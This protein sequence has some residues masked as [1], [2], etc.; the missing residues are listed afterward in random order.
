VEKNEVLP[1]NLEADVR[2]RDRTYGLKYHNECT[3]PE[4]RR[5]VQSVIGD[6]IFTTHPIAHVFLTL[7]F[8]GRNKTNKRFFLQI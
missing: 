1:E 4:P 6:F 7:E 2:S 5:I 8:F 3:D